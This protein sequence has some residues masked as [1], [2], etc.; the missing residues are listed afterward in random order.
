VEKI[1]KEFGLLSPY[2]ENSSK[3]NMKRSEKIAVP[4]YPFNDNENGW[5]DDTLDKEEDPFFADFANF[6]DDNA[7][8]QTVMTEQEQDVKSVKFKEESQRASSG[9]LKPAKYSKRLDEA[10]ICFDTEGESSSYDKKK[11][12]LTDENRGRGRSKNLFKSAMG[13]IKRGM[14]NI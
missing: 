11:S 14:Y 12:K 5:G 7:F 8:R 4:S 2:K 3:E 6:G 9:I 10:T 13:V 1:A